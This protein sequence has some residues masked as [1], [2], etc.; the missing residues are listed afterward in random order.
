MV[1]IRHNSN[2]ANFTGMAKK[3]SNKDLIRE[4]KRIEEKKP[5]AYWYNQGDKKEFETELAKRKSK[6]LIKSSAGVKKAVKQ[7]LFSF[8]DLMRM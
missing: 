6:G 7:K 1:E 5:S 8:D 2:K 3:L 4:I